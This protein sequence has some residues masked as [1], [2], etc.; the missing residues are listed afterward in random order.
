[1]NRPYEVF[2]KKWLRKYYKDLRER[3]RSRYYKHNADDEDALLSECR[4]LAELEW[5]RQLSDDALA[6]LL[7]HQAMREE[8]IKEL[9]SE[10][11]PEVTR[12]RSLDHLKTIIDAEE[13]L[14]KEREMIRSIWGV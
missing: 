8:W 2:E 14:R 6:A 9:T 4:G 13:M 1:M 11:V 7:D 3:R 5:M 10:K 12:K